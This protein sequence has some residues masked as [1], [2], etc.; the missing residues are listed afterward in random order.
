LN[1]KRYNTGLITKKLIYYF[2]SEKPDIK[3]KDSL[4]GNSCRTLLMLAIISS[5]TLSMLVAGAAS[6]I[7]ISHNYQ[8]TYAAAK[9]STSSSSSSSSKGESSSGR[10]G[11]NSTAPI[12]SKTFLTVTTQVSGGTSKPSDFTI[13]VD[14][15]SP[16]PKSFSGSSSG[17]SVT[18]RSGSYSVSADSISGYSRSY[19]SGCSG[20]ASGGVPIKCT[21]TNIYTLPPPGSTTFLNVITKVDN[22]NGGTKKPSDF[23]ITVSGNSPKPSLFGGSS[24]GTPV[25]LQAGKYS[26]SSST[27][28]GYTTS[29]SSGCSGIASGGLVKCTIT[30]QFSG[31]PL[32]ST[33]F[34]SV[35]THVD[36]THGGTKKPSDFTITVSGNNPK[37]ASFV[38]SSSGTSVTLL[39]GRY[40]VSESSLSGYTTTYSSECSG[41]ASGGLI[42]CTITNKYV[43]TTGTLVVTTI[44]DNTNG[45]TKKPSDFTISVSGNSPLP[46]LFSGSSTGTSVRL[47]SGTYGVGASSIPDYRTSY[48]SGCSG[49]ANG[50]VPI[51]CTITNQYNGLLPPSPP[52][53]PAGIIITSD[54]KSVYLI[55][56]TFVKVNRFGTNYTIAGNM[57]FINSSRNLITSTIVNDFEMNPNIGYVVS[58]S[59]SLNTS[60]QPGLPNPFVGKDAINHKITNETENAIT[61]ASTIN[62]PGKNVKINCSFGMILADYKC[63]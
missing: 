27:I 28:D 56:S 41:T 33:T 9:N 16:S 44:V 52:I 53:K 55:P 10:F 46:K 42:K 59:S 35:F 47:G 13:N 18:L 15:N 12:G 61:A 1:K 31:S 6:S 58:N 17:T 30:N 23:T 11:K 4:R 62:P 34:L 26:V 19:S 25:T 63:S 20:N 45:G 8:V 43:P 24:S 50:G 5:V 7:S 51:K 38:G 40:S 3:L 14:G 22:S 2:I 48:S 37:P 49:T 29:Y 32:G 21:I 54:S 57:S 36:N 60:V 39:A